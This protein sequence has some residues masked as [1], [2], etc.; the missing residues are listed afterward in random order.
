MM[1]IPYFLLTETSVPMKPNPITMQME[2]TYP[3]ETS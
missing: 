1:D 2:A 3:P